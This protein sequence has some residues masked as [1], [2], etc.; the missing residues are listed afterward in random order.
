MDSIDIEN[1][2]YFVTAQMN[3]KG[4]ILRGSIEDKYIFP[5]EPYTVDDFPHGITI[6]KSGKY[7]GHT[8]YSQEAVKIDLLE[9][10]KRN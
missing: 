6:S 5:R 9:V 7:I 2:N 4:V 10:L 8:S 1:G 3:D